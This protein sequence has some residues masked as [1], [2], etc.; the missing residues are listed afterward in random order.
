MAGL[1]GTLA[2]L[3]SLS[4]ATAGGARKQVG[5]RTVAAAVKAPKVPNAKALKRKYGG[6][7][8]TFIGD[9]VG[10]SHKRDLLLASR[11]T[12]PRPRMR[13]Q[14][15]AIK[16]ETSAPSGVFGSATLIEARR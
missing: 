10:N 14:S 2:L 13:S 16:K 15:R 1:A 3:V 8:I 12:K 6:Q 9:S 7:K 4:V 5:S 11:F